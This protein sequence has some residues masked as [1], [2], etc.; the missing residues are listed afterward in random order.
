MYPVVQI[1]SRDKSNN[2]GQ[3][4]GRSSGQLHHISGSITDHFGSLPPLFLRDQ[5]TRNG[6]SVGGNKRRVETAIKDHCLVN[7]Q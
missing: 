3:K 5:T 7:Q 1:H 6:F 2:Q 4:N